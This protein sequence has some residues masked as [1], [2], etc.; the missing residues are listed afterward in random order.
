MATIYRAVDSQLGR[1][2]A[3]KIL[4]PNTAAIPDFVARFRAG[5]AGRRLAEPPERGPGLRL[6][7]WTR[8]GPYIVMGYV[9][10]EDLATILRRRSGPLQP[11]QAARIV[12]AVGPRPGGGPCARD[13]PSRREAGQH[14]AGPGRPGAD[15]RLRDRPGD[16]RGPDDPARDHPGLGP[17][18]LPE[19]ARGE[20]ATERSDIYSLGIVL[21]EL[22]T[23]TPPVRG[24][25]GR[26][27]RDGPPERSRADAV[28]L[29]GRHP[30]GARG[31]R[32]QGARP[33]SGRPVRQ[34]QCDGRRHRALAGGSLRRR[35]APSPFPRRVPA[36]PAWPP[37]RAWPPELGLAAG[38]GLGA[39]TRVRAARPT[40]E[41]WLPALPARM[42]A[43]ACPIRRMPTPT[44]HRR[45]GSRPA[46]RSAATTPST[47]SPARAGTSPWAWVAGLLGLLILVV[48]GFLIFKLVTGPPSRLRRSSSRTSWARS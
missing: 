21:F 19:Q 34:R 6:R 10:G 26:L 14:H 45:P 15:D 13:H 33:R 32:P 27:D 18:L 12:A 24:R 39:G 8:S 30:A 42:P 22:L 46:R 38:T 17:L 20:P 2:V 11:R 41:P 37:V 4:R 36:W 47:T 7:R 16:Q 35:A 1:D 29:P 3:V 44:P 23:G 25:L 48:A 31:D 40:R 28:Q 5:G 43:P 9:D